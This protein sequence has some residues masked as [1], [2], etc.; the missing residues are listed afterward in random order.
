M[1]RYGRLF[2]VLHNDPPKLPSR[3]RKQGFASID[4]S[5]QINKCGSL[6]Q[7]GLAASNKRLNCDVRSLE[8]S[9]SKKS[10]GHV[11]CSDSNNFTCPEPM[12]ITY[13]NHEPIPPPMCFRCGQK[14][15]QLL[16]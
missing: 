2:R 10:V 9:Y 13:Q 1:A 6:I 14:R 5:C 15:Q 3:D 16:L 7:Q 4:S 11:I 12:G 8:P